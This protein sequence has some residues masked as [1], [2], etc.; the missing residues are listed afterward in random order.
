MA[1]CN[2][3]LS[4]PDSLVEVLIWLLAYVA[5]EPGTNIETVMMSS[6]LPQLLQVR[7]TFPSQF[8][9][10]SCYE[11]LSAKIAKLFMT[12]LKHLPW[13]NT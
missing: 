10:K 8:L 13:N 5:T 12:T 2:T 9:I 1:Q 11:L 3:L 4:S 7:L 6:V